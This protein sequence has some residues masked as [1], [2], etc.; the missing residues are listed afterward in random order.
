MKPPLTYYGGKQQ[1]AEIIVRLIPPH[2]IYAEPFIGGAAVYFAKPPSEVEIINDT[3]SEI[4][5]FYEVMKNDFSALQKE[6]DATLHSRKAHRH[7]RVIYENPDLFD[8]VKRAWALWTLANMSFSA[9]L[10]GGYGY[11]LTNTTGKCIANKIESFTAMLADR[12]RKTQIECCDALKIIETR[13]TPE[14]FYYLDPPYPDTDQGHYN[15]YSSADF[16]EL[17]ELLTKIQGKFLLSSFRHDVLAEYTDKN[18][19]SQLEI[20]MNKSMSAKTGRSTQKIEVFTANYPIEKAG[21][22]L[23]SLF[24]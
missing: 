1:L 14:T 20:R 5:N 10:D 18:K 22:G 15:G 19:W 3:N 6:I 23:S 2:K 4:V 16:A 13:D 7:A 8:H 12:L 24:D 21:Y 17:L 11:D 9:I